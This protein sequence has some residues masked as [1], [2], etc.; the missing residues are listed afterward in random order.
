M[1]NYNKMRAK[2]KIVCQDFCT[3]SRNILDLE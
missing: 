3:V 1:N 2:K